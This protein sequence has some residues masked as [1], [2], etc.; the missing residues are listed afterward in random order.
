[1]NR[2]AQLLSVVFFTL[3]QQVYCQIL[4]HE[5]EISIITLGPYQA[6]LYSAFGHSAIRV[7]DPVN[8]WDAI[9]NYGIFDTDQP[10]F[11]LNFVSGNPYYK[12]GV[13]SYDN[14]LNSAI[15]KNAFYPVS[16]H[17]SS[18]KSCNSIYNTPGKNKGLIF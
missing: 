17:H 11:Y 1:M 8:N 14:L 10:N 7:S 3:T 18:S 9:Y 13:Y 2:L 12:L 16:F 5:S 6:E 4:S 15:R